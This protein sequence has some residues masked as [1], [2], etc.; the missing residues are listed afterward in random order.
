M[1]LILRKTNFIPPVHFCSAKVLAIWNHDQT[2]S[3]EQIKAL[4]EELAT[5]SKQQLMTLQSS[6]YMRM[7]PPEAAAHDSRRTRIAE[8]HGLL[9]TFKAPMSH[10]VITPTSIREV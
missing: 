3:P 1:R 10:W 2:M 6:I 8:I 4:S 7:T 5:L 9:G